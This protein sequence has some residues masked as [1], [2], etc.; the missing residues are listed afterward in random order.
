MKKFISAAACVCAIFIICWLPKGDAKQTVV[1]PAPEK[2][3]NN[4]SKFII[5]D[6]I[7]DA[8]NIEMAKTMPESE[9]PQN[10]PNADE[11]SAIIIAKLPQIEEAFKYFTEVKVKQ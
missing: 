7:E 5:V 2:E 4:K 8:R 3:V 10:I 11:D 6:S 9:L 1:K